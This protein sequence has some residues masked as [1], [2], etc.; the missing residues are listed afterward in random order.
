MESSLLDEL[1]GE[2]ESKY[3]LN[4]T[5]DIKRKTQ[6]IFTESR[7]QVTIIRKTN[8]IPKSRD[9]R[10]TISQSVI[11][12]QPSLHTPEGVYAENTKE[13]E[14]ASHKA[15]EKSFWAKIFFGDGL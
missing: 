9:H 1:L 7:V 5:M 12:S 4:E 8:H 15:G 3:D 11:R 10:T 14:D 6:C 2:T 13:P